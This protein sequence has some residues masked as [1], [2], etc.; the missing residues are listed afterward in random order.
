[1]KSAHL[2]GDGPFTKEVSNTLSEVHGGS[3]VLLTT[4]CTAALEMC[5]LLLDIQPSDEVIVPSFTF[6]SSANAFVLAGATIVF[7]DIDPFTFNIDPIEVEKAITTK[8]RAVVAVNYGG[9]N[10]VTPELNRVIL[11][12]DLILIEDN[13]H[14][15]FSSSDGRALGTNSALGTL[16]FHESKNVTC[17]DGGA[18]VVNDSRFFERAEI[19]R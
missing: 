12:H 16:S 6:V 7:V 2:S 17:G 19:I 1:M 10:A 15:L 9:A 8:T 13:A 18:L 11:E 5:A 14:G 4:S 3:P